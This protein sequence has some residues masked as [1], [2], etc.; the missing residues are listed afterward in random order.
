MLQGEKDKDV[1]SALGGGTY[2]S[3]SVATCI[4]GAAM[5]TC[6]RYLESI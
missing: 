4:G 5:P 2:I 1:V 3:R 6:V